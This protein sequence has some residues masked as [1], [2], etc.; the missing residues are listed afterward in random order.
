MAAVDGAGT[1]DADAYREILAEVRRRG[2]EVE[3]LEVDEPSVQRVTIEAEKQN[4]M[5]DSLNRG[6]AGW[7]CGTPAPA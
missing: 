7:C 2:I 6:G 3:I 5:V 4:S 1:S